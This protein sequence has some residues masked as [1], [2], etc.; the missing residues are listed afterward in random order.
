MVRLPEEFIATKY[1]G[2]FF[3]TKNET[4]YSIKLGGLLRPLPLRYPDRFNHL[5]IPAFYISVK[6]IRR[7][8]PLKNLQELAAK[9]RVETIIPVLQ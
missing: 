5:H 1:N 9:P 3:N 4:L 6:G 8:Y 7:A 2:Y